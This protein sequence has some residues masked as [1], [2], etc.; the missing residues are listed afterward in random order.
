M[1]ESWCTPK[2]GTIKINFDG[3]FDSTT[4]VLGSGIVGRDTNSSVLRIR[5]WVNSHIAT[6][7]AVEALMC[8]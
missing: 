1:E 2:V 8:L 7:F 4:H 6:P 5:I 3:A